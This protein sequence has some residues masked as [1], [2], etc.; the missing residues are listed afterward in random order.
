MRKKPAVRSSKNK[1]KSV[2]TSILSIPLFI[3][4]L[5]G[6]LFLNLV[7]ILFKLFSKTYNFII[8]FSSKV[9]VKISK[10]NKRLKK[11]KKVISD[12]KT[13]SIYERKHLNIRYIFRK[14]FKK[15]KKY[16]QN[17]FFFLNYFKSEQFITWLKIVII[18]VKFFILGAFV[19]GL[20][21]SIYEIDRFMQALPLPNYLN[22]RDIPATTKIFDRNG[23]FLYEIYAD[24]NRVPVKLTEVPLIVRQATIAIEDRDFYK[25]TGFSLRAIARALVNNYYYDDTR[26]GGSTIT[27][28]LIRSALL[29]PDRTITRKLKEIFLSIWAEQIYSKDEILEMYLNQVPYGGTAWGIE[30]ASQTYF[31][32]SIRDVNLAQAALLAGLP[33][34]PSIYS[35]FGTHPELSKK[36]QEEVLDKMAENSFITPGEVKSAKEVKLNYVTPHSAIA[37]PHF[38]MYVKDLLEQRLGP[39]LVKEGGLR[40]MTTLDLDIQ[41]TAQKIVSQNI[42]GL[43][44]LNVNNGAVLITRP[45]NGEILA[46]VGSE[47]YFDL[48]NQGNVNVTL[49]IR[50]PGSAIKIVTYAAALKDGFTAATL[51]DDSPVVYRIAGQTSYI[52]VNYDGKF[53]GTVPLRTAFASSFNVPAVKILEKIGIKNMLD[54][55]RLMGITSWNDGES[56]GLSITLGGAG[57]TMLDMSRVYG[58]IANMGVRNELNPILKITDFRGN[59]LPSPVE[60]KEINAASPGV[61]FIISSILSDNRARTP[62]FGEHS[63][64]EIKGKTVAVK[65]GTSDNKRDNWTIGFTPDFLVTVW[66]GNNDNS[67]MDPRLSSGITGA[68]PIWNNIMTALLS[69]KPDKPFTPTSDVVGMNCYNRTEYFL[70]GTEPKRGCPRYSTISPSPSPSP[71]I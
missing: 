61:A 17:Q 24:E 53:H 11:N 66:V 16:F 51:L 19:V 1:W 59:T 5:V 40:V 60:N 32:K 62:A 52:P 37:A 46:M 15:I 57:V 22:S 41:E 4:K 33:A 49:S 42:S 45:Q 18:K 39:R 35:P 2:I 26:Q 55:A 9:L 56:Y 64:L 50:P 3:L 28:Q 38:V 27:Q 12:T 65:T 47:N 54:Q 14:E 10:I 30:A 58:T 48:A 67:P 23:K 31:S 70:I 6:D 63:L 13:I 25:H 21:F 36:R 8:T 29:T 44:R 43:R 34:A 7:F 69:D 20:I 71:K 68:A